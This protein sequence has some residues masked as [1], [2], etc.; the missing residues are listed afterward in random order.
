MPK[1]RPFC[2]SGSCTR[3]RCGAA[4]G[5]QVRRKKKGATPRP[6]RP[7]SMVLNLYAALLW[8]SA[9]T[10]S[11]RRTWSASWSIIIR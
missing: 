11:M 9:E 7:Y 3:L 10:F 2:I 4:R 5:G 1:R 6:S 8:R